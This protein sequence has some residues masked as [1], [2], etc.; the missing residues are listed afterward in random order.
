MTAPKSEPRFEADDRERVLAEALPMR[1]QA[2]A[3]RS[4]P[5][6]PGTEAWRAELDVPRADVITL[7]MRSPLV[8]LLRSSDEQG[9]EPRHHCDAVLLDDSDG[10]VVLWQR[11]FRQPGWEMFRTLSPYTD[12]LDVELENTTHGSRLI[13]TWH[14]HPTTTKARQQ[15]IV[16]GFFCVAGAVMWVMRARYSS[17]WIF[18]VLLASFGAYFL[19]RGFRTRGPATA[20][21]AVL[22]E[23][24]EPHLVGS[25]RSLRS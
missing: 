3:Q 9:L 14:R 21:L 20:S 13:A 24:L 8:E 22:K 17:T 1:R 2:L 11:V 25:I 12:T 23:I 7:L 16:P 15:L 6:L 4:G 5:S 18:I 19:W 10:G